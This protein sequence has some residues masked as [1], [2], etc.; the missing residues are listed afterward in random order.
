MVYALENYLFKALCAV[1]RAICP[2]LQFSVRVPNEVTFRGTFGVICYTLG[3]ICEV[4]SGP[5][6]HF[7]GAVGLFFVSKNGLGTTGAPRAAQEAPPPFRRQP[8]GDLLEPFF[9]TFSH[10]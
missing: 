9:H 2:N 10:F 4:I 3:V 8:F 5:W 7:G 6:G 1:R